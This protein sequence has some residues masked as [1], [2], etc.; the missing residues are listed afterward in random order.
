M[1]FGH[2]QGRAQLSYDPPP[3]KLPSTSPKSQP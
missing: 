1:G 2:R 3:E